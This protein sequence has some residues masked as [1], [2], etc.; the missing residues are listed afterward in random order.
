MLIRRPTDAARLSAAMLRAPVVLLVG[1]R[2]A[3]KTTLARELLGVGDHYF[4]AEN[5]TDLVQLRDP[6]LALQDLTGT[7]IV[8]EA[9]LVDGLFS[10]LRVLADRPARPARFLVLG[11]ASAEFVG[12][13]SQSLAGRVE[14]LELT[15]L[16]V[17]DV[18]GDEVD[19]LWLRGGLPASFDAPDLVASAVW[20]DNY[21]TTFLSTDLP[22]L[23]SRVPTS[24]MRRAWTMLSHYHGQTWNGAE[25]SRALDVD[26]KSGRRYLDQLTDALVVRQLLPWFVNT[27]K[28]QVK[29]PRIYIRD[30]G[31]LHRLQSIETRAD[32]LAHPVV[33]ASWEGFVIEQLATLLNGQPMYYWRTQQ[34]AE[35]DVYVK[36]RGGS[37]GIEIKRASAPTI[38]K[39]IR[40]ALDDLQLDHLAIAYPGTARYDVDPRV[41][42]VPFVELVDA[43]TPSELISKITGR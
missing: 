40:V 9:Q 14:I 19:R 37:Y 24:T 35:L 2:Q 38:T 7:V 3:G 31:V 13:S 27:G 12:L 39:S 30:T 23:G 42:V 8:D 17:T 21:I 34:G 18:G 43:T 28:R 22:Q 20:R 32:L 1:P 11:S 26:A 4:D 36:L 16:R 5:P 6:M 15:G 29:A 25:F 10:V 33:G 41:S